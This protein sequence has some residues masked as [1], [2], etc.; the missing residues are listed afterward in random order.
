MKPFTPRKN[1]TKSITVTASN[2][3]VKLTEAAGTV[4]VRIHNG[5]VQTVFIE[6]GDVAATAATTTG[7]PVPAG[8]VEVLQAHSTGTLYAAAIGTGANSRN[9][10]FTPGSGI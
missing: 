8:A 2:Q 1:G 6:F 5:D 3:R 4:D 7:V 10:Y 9:I